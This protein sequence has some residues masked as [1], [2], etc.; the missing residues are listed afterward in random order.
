[1]KFIISDELASVERRRLD[2]FDDL[3]NSVGFLKIERPEKNVIYFFHLKVF[4]PFRGLGYSKLLLE[5]AVKISRADQTVDMLTINACPFEDGALTAEQ[6]AKIYWEF[7]FRTFA[8]TNTTYNM[9]MK[10]R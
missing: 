2:L 9:R 3:G 5:E 1:M 6:L 8:K 10:I 4:K 7:G